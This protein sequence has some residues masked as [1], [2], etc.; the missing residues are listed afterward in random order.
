MEEVG[1]ELQLTADEVDRF[2]KA[3]R[4]G[5]FREMLCD[6][7]Q[8][9]SDPAN[10]KKYEEEIKLLEQERGNC[11]EFIH[12]T[13][14]RV[15]KTSAGGKQKCF[16]NICSNEKV[17]KP[18]FKGAVL[19]DGRRGQCWSLPLSLSPGRQNTAPKGNEYVI[20]D[21]IFHP[22]TLHMAA[23][24]KI[25]MDMVHHT[26][27]DEVQKAFKVILDKNNVREVKTKYKGTPQPC[28]IRKPIPGYEAKG[29]PEE[30]DPLAFPYPHGPQTKP[31]ESPL[32]T[33]SSFKIQPQKAEEPTKPNYTV[34]YRS[35][36]DLQDFR[37]SRDSAQSPRPKEIVITIDLPLLKTV[38][39]TSLEVKE[40]ILWLESK[41]PAYRLELPLSY[42][43]D[44]DNGE[45]KFN[46]Q[47]RQLTVTLPV[48]P[49]REEFSCFDPA[50]PVNDSQGVG[51][52]T[53]EG[54]GRTGEQKR[55]EGKRE[56]G[57]GAKDGEAGEE[58]CERP[59]RKGQGSEEQ[60]PQ[61]EPLEEKGEV[62]E[63][64]EQLQNKQNRDEDSCDSVM[65]DDV[66][67]KMNFSAEE[68]TTAVDERTE[69]SSKAEHISTS[70]ELIPEEGG[71][72][73]GT[74]ASRDLSVVSL[75]QEEEDAGE[76]PE[77]QVFQTPERDKKPPAATLRE[78]DAN[79]NETVIGDHSTSAGFVFQNK[80]IYELD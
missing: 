42:P 18:D 75:K 57:R 80:L 31:S 25:F 12:P 47:R 71:E 65:G 69:A 34:K 52:E 13:P 74:L 14:F 23:K 44:E 66:A 10:R 68:E 28:V 61:Y 3:F 40:K 32:K 8:E 49:P 1:D 19:K 2:T 58:N 79:G 37:R 50:T 22:D 54:R 5:K 48:Q 9:I 78:I 67:L 59:E 29:P 20:Y 11:I 38:G 21:V 63:E 53:S 35:V 62:K 77:E 76:V 27:I 56:G 60:L 4:D 30:T 15:L 16:I 70:D 39:D 7:A 41:H 36:I 45:A 26:A 51:E 24:S 33:N 55:G 72:A 43:V 64:I 17:G 46:K 6:Y 73:K